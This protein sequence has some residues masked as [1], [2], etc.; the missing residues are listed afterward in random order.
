MTTYKNKSLNELS[1][2]QSSKLLLPLTLI[3]DRYQY[4]L[5]ISSPRYNI[6]G[7]RQSKLSSMYRHFIEESTKHY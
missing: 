3:T 1:L 4:K 6:G 7:D 2:T 5:T